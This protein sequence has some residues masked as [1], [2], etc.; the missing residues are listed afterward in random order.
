MIENFFYKIN[1]ILPCGVTFLNLE[2]FQPCENIYVGGKPIT[3]CMI[4]QD[5]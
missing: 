2:N 5:W 3:I 4:M 1:K